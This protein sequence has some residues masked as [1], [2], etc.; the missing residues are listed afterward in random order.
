MDIPIPNLTILDAIQF[1]ADAWNRVEATTIAS[2]WRKTGIVPPMPGSIDEFLNLPLD[3]EEDD[4]AVQCLID[5][6][7]PQNPLT[8]REYL[9]ID[10]TLQIEDMLDDDAIISLVQGEEAIEEEEEDL[11][12]A[13]PIITST[14]AVEL[15][16]KLT[17]FFMH[18]EA[19]VHISDKF[20]SELKNVK[21]E[22]C[23]TI[24]DSKVQTD[25]SSFLEPI[26]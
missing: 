17:C 3:T 10:F 1:T 2:S 20:L 12:P 24:V 15:I 23:R 14:N 16:D 11:E 6:L 21:K 25:I 19:R 22:L 9:E 7:Q 18:G 13:A 26:D 5:R 8:A 4:E